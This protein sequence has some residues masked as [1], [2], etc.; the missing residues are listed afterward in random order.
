M[1]VRPGELNYAHVRHFVDRLVTV[2]DQQIAA[3]VRWMFERTHL[4]AEPS[5]AATVA[6]AL[7]SGAN[8]PPPVVA[9][10]SG[11]NLDPADLTKYVC[12]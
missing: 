8:Y 9:I 5:G 6:A 4:V 12:E 1:A 10:V 2:E 11:G 7:A 3:A